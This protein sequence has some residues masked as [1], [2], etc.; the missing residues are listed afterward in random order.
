[1]IQSC[2]NKGSGKST[3]LVVYIIG[4]SGTLV[5]M[6]YKEKN[7]MM[8]HLRERSLLMCTGGG[9]GGTALKLHPLGLFTFSK[10][11]SPWSIYFLIQKVL[12]RCDMFYL[13]KPYTSVVRVPDPLSIKIN[14]VRQ[15]KKNA[16]NNTLKMMTLPLIC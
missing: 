10:I 14:F 12:I 6:L 16:S 7:Q 11:A 8:R 2:I 9:G 13:A 5:T 4:G 15:H 3:F 1:M